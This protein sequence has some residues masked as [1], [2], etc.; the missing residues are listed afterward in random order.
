MRHGETVWNTE[1]R[2][3]GRTNVELSEFGREMADSCADGM[4]D[5]PIDLCISSPLIRARETAERI[6]E[7]NREYRSRSEEV[8]RNLTAAGV[9]M[10]ESFLPVFSGRTSGLRY[11]TDERLIEAAFGPWE[12]L[13]FRGGPGVATVADFGCYWTDPESDLIPE[14]VERLPAVTQRVEN[15]LKDLVNCPVLKG[16]NVL[17]VVHGVVIRSFNYLL[18]GRKEYTASVTRN[19]EVIRTHIG[20]DGQLVSDGREI[21]YDKS[22]LHDNYFGALAKGTK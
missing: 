14:G 5:I 6:L 10:S 12:G 16:K 15:S 7:K 9:P 17:L 4:K 20:P 11:L 13:P 3:Q 1:G 2:L 18:N 8:F 21:Y 22:M 19:C